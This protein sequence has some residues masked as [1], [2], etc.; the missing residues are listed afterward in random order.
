[1]FK[2]F[3]NVVKVA[4]NLFLEVAYINCI[5]RIYMMNNQKLFTNNKYAPI[6]Q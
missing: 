3:L 2:L 6:K 4:F 1:M 5:K